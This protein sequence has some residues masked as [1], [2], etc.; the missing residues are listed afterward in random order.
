MRHLHLLGVLI[1]AS[2]LATCRAA[3]I[4]ARAQTQAPPGWWA[5]LMRPADMWSG[6]DTGASSFGQ[7]PR[8]QY[9][10]VP[11]TQPFPG[12]GRVY[13]REAA[14]QAYGYV[15]ALALAPSGPP[16]E[17]GG[18]LPSVVSTPL[19][20][21]FWVANHTPA[22]LLAG[23][24]DGAESLIELAPFSKLLV[25][26]PAVGQRYYV[27]DGRSEQLGY[28]EATLIG[29]S[30]PPVP[31]EFD[32]PPSLAPPVAPSYRPSWVAAQRATDLWSGMTGGTSF[33]RVAA[34]DQLLVMAPA[35]GP[36]LHVLNPKTKN[37]AFVDAAAVSPS[38]GPKPA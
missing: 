34:G 16:P 35:E 29:P 31:G 12:G 14:E 7:L 36:R 30:D 32:P 27:Q 5:Q 18:S 25:L 1:L 17:E 20:R 37:Y 13:V 9:V 11:D 26:A 38:T 33:G 2:L 4:S 15:D 23:P 10:F 24:N 21:P 22:A 28:I 6:P 3:P 8:G 19:F